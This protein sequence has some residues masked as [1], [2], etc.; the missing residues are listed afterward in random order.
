[1]IFKA[2]FDSQEANANG[3]VVAELGAVA[4]AVEVFA[5]QLKGRDVLFFIDAEAVEAALV[6]GASA[7]Y[8]LEDVLGGVWRR[9]VEDSVGA[10]FDRVPTDAN[11]SDG[12]SRG[13]TDELQQLG[14]EWRCAGRAAKGLGNAIRQRR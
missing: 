11:V 10:Y 1:M 2:G 4:M 3:V 12:P 8:D 9:L 13:F 7:A 6:K 5:D 14:V